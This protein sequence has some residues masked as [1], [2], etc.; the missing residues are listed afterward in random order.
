MELLNVGW[1]ALL[2]PLVRRRW[3]SGADPARLRLLLGVAGGAVLAWILLMF[4][5]PPSLAFVFQGSYATMLVLFLLAA[6]VVSVLPKRVAGAVVAAQVLYFATLWVALVWAPR[7][8]SAH[9]PWYVALAAT[10]ALAVGAVLLLIGRWQ[11]GDALPDPDVRPDG[12]TTMFGW[13]TPPPRSPAPLPLPTKSSSHAPSTSTSPTPS[14]RA[15]SDYWPAPA[16]TDW[17]GHRSSAAWTHPGSPRSAGSSK[18][19]PAA[20]WPPRSCGCNT[21]APSGR[22]RPPT[23]PTSG[24]DGYDPCAPAGA[25]P[26]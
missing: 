7:L 10:G 12:R 8:P 22:S 3:W 25:G 21:T 16:S 4:G 26:A 13:S 19:S 14:R 20:A 2:V 6:S 24:S 18:R 5:S 15:T 23:D 9:P 17:P 1:L 11:P